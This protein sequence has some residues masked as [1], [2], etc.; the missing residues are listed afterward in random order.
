[1]TNK[2]VETIVSWKLIFNTDDLILCAPG[3]VGGVGLLVLCNNVDSVFA[4]P[5]GL[6]AIPA[7]FYVVL[8][9]SGNDLET[10]RAAHGAGWVASHSNSTV[11]FWETYSEFHFNKVHVGPVIGGIIPTWIAMYFVVAFSSCLDVAAI[12]MEVGRRLDFNHELKTVGLS[13]FFSG[14][15]GGYTGS[16]IF[17]DT[18]LTMRAGITSNVNGIV[19][20][21]CLL[22]F[23][24]A[25]ISLT[26]VVPRFFFGTVLIFIGI[27]LM[28]E[29]IWEVR[30]LVSRQEYCL[31]WI[32]FL[33]INAFNNLELGF[34]VGVGAS[35]LAFVHRYTQT[36]FLTRVH[37][38]STIH[39]GFKERQIIGKYSSSIVTL[40]LQGY[41]FFGSALNTLREVENNVVLRSSDGLGL[42]W[43][44]ETR[45]D[46]V[47]KGAHPTEHVVL[48]F[49]KVTGMDASAA[50]NCFASIVQSL[51][52]QGIALILAGVPADLK[53]IMQ[54]NGVG[55]VADVD[56]SPAD[57]ADTNI[58]ISPAVQ[59]IG[60][61][62]RAA[63][64][65]QHTVSTAEVTVPPAEAPAQRFV[66]SLDA[67]LEWCEDD[68]LHM[69]TGSGS[70]A[71]VQVNKTRTV[72]S[73]IA[74][75]ITTT[76]DGPVQ[77]TSG[78]EPICA[79]HF[80]LK[81]VAKG[82]EI[83]AEG[84]EADTVYFIAKGCVVI[85]NEIGA[86]STTTTSTTDLATT[87]ST[88]TSKGLTKRLVGDHCPMLATKLDAS[89]EEVVRL[90]FL[91]SGNMQAIVLVL[92]LMLGATATAFGARAHEQPC[93]SRA[94]P[95][96]T[97]HRLLCPGFMFAGVLPQR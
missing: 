76:G 69:A 16:Y 36:K 57:P 77:R 26:A 62:P 70:S 95:L 19:I 73:I 93:I 61:S 32:T 60:E 11:Q 85:T 6:L 91:R 20:I 82:K 65:S 39:R 94:A 30:H 96:S 78:E 27:S 34:A 3:V 86:T 5:A 25:P 31:I 41:I 63:F 80:T 54:N 42:E 10:A 40:E 2:D 58:S 81:K 55:E 56:C 21:I 92:V 66:D 37:K 35:I 84:D 79:E 88:T 1:M 46:D 51:G 45:K 75:Y 72:P 87:I 28:I 50:R 47:P 89:A 9:A 4:L 13:N 67:A 14:I 12:Q 68:L 90:G 48:D 59:M 33:A 64:V 83:F 8:F 38:R 18:I 23:F 74:E 49:A 17:T 53:K 97:N 29:W 52:L 15:T 44:S 43:L 22:I 24:A 71:N 7:I